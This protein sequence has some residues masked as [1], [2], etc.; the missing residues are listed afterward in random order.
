MNLPENLNTD[1]NKR[2]VDSLLERVRG[3]DEEAK[4]RLLNMLDEEMDLPYL[5]MMEREYAKVF[6]CVSPEHAT[7]LRG[8]F[9]ETLNRT[10]EYLVSEVRKI[11]QGEDA[12]DFHFEQ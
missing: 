7:M 11:L 2:A 3:L 4:S 8:R 10:R 1:R 5:D 6:R 12:S 9:V